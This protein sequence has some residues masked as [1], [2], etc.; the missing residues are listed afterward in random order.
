MAN[1]A[2]DLTSALKKALGWFDLF[3]PNQGH[4]NYLLLTQLPSVSPHSQNRIFTPWVL[5]PHLLSEAF[6]RLVE[7]NQKKAEAVLSHWLTHND[8]TFKWY[9]SRG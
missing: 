7:R 6:L 3:Y 9:S 5:L 1:A 4:P 2:D 8:P